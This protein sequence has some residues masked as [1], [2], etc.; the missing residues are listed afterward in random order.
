MTYEEASAIFNYCCQKLRELRKENAPSNNIWF[1]PNIES[2]IKQMP[3]QE[4]LF[5]KITPTPDAVGWVYECEADIVT[6]IT[7][8]MSKY[9]VEKIFL[10]CFGFSED[11]MPEM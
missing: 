9:E 7:K 11:N 3:E 1:A 8:H 4:E 10:T 6:A 5:R 2:F